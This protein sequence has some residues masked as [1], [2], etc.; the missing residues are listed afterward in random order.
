MVSKPNLLR[1]LVLGAVVLG[2]AAPKAQAQTA[3]RKTALSA[4]IGL[5]QYSGNMGSDF[6]NRSGNDL[7]VG[8][9]GTITRYLSPSFDVAL[10]A[11]TKPT[12]SAAS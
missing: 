2:M 5:M 6:W 8:G 4:N 9:G 11:T 12:N 1:G 7:S 3:D 10:L